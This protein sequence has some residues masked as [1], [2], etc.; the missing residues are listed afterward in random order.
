[1]WLLNG[2]L[3]K[4]FRL[5]ELPVKA[6]VAMPDNQHARDASYDANIQLFNVNDGAAL[7]TFEHDNSVLCISLVPDGRRFVTG[8]Q[9]RATLDLRA[10]AGF[11]TP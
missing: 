6:L 10:R 1:M 3:K 8:S 9:Q 5:H 2:T 7:R 11:A 4:T